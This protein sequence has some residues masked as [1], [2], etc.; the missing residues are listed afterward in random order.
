MGSIGMGASHQ[1]S[2]PYFLLLTVV[3]RLELDT[4]AVDGKLQVLT[5]LGSALRF[6]SRMYSSRKT[7]GMLK[8]CI[9]K[10][11]DER[12]RLHLITVVPSQPS[13]IFALQSGNP[14][15]M[16]SKSFDHLIC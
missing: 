14:V 4:G 3:T 2:L 16:K 5:I 12:R 15:S 11:F 7:N 9:D 1:R 8:R 6:I 13:Y 10:R